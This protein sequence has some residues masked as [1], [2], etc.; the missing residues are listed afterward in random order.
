MSYTSVFGGNT[1]YP[2]DVSYLSIPLSANTPLEWPLESS[3][4]EDPAA[5]II[6]V[7]PSASGFSVVLPNATLTGAGQTILFNNIDATFSFFVKDYAGNTL[8]T[9]TAGTQWQVYLAAT[10]TPAGTWRVFRYGASTATVQPSALAG[11]G[12]TVTGTTLSQSLPVTTFSTTG[13]TVATSNRASAFVW[14]ATGSGTLNLLTAASA[15]NNFFVFVRN[16]GGGDLTVEP[17]GTETINSALSLVLRPGDSAT[18]ITDGVSWYTIGLGQ[19]AVFAF[20]YTSIS[21]TGGTV[22]LSGSQLN[23]IAY[24]FVGTLTSNC[25]IVVP[26]TIQQYWVNNATTGPFQLFIQTSAGTPTGVN[27]GA[28][29]IYY[30]DGT[31]MVLASDPTTLTTPIVISDGGTGS[32][33]ASGARLNLGITSFADAIV[34]ATTGASVRTTISAAASGANSDITSLSGLTTPLSV[35]QGGTGTATA[36][37]TGSVVFAG[38]SGVYSQDN[39]NLFWD[40]TND[41]LGI[42]TST[43]TTK[44]DVVGSATFGAAIITGTGLTTGDAQLELGAN[45][46]GSGLAYID[47]HAISGGDFQARLVRYAGAN[48][49]MDLIQTGTGGMVI[50]NEGSADTVFKTNALERMRI[51]NAGNV[52]IGVSSPPQLLA[53]GNTTDQFGAGVAGAVT[54]AYFGSPSTG[55][56]GI[57]RLAYDRGTGNFDFIGGSVASPATQM[58]ITGTGNV[59]IGTSSPQ[60]LLHVLAGANNSVLVRGPINLGTGGS[61]YAVNSTNSATTPLEFGASVYSFTGGSVGIGTFTPSTTL[62]VVGT[63]TATSF[64]G[65]GT[66]LTGTA[67]AL[68]IGGNAATATSA[69]TAGSVTN[70]ITFNNS[71]SGDASGTTFN[72]SAARTISY[73]TVGAPS[74]GGANATGTWGISISGNAAT[75][76]NATNLNGQAA[77]FYTDIP[78]RLGYTP[79]QQGGGTGQLSNKVYIGWTGS[80]LGVQVD[81]TNFGATWPISINGTA[82]TATTAN[83]LNTG[84]TYTAVGYVSTATAGT[85]LQVGDNSGIRNFGSGST[86]YIDVAGGSASAGSLVLRNTN[87]FTPMATFSGTGTQLTSLGVGTAPSGTAGEIRATNNVTAYY[88]SDARLKENVQPITNALGIVSAVGGKTFDWTDAYIADHGGEDGYFIQKSDFGVIAQDVEAVFPLAVRTREDGTKAVDYEKL[89]AVAF[90]AIA[91]LRAEVNELRQQAVKVI[92]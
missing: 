22:T 5:R 41:R 72:G 59:G 69:T 13:I 78:A 47:L 51:T 44:L 39:A 90:A 27:Q 11:F 8:A 53:V 18:V 87:S 28:K 24:K 73:N 86:I 7:D 17:A 58:T 40:N 3:G 36:L 38:A 70:S 92:K 45:R 54:T 42:G 91:E 2:S 64:T 74:T 65:A 56:G 37:T 43:P 85:A 66:G 10:T 16:E 79:V 61:I 80:Q 26:A 62:Q 19:E 68:S 83:A 63:V 23:R 48:G 15:G 52:G 88:S 71:G 50:S 4:T 33:T 76:S 34:T 55:S 32:T 46:T 81:T 31:N 20:D 67:S 30:C 12:L 35:A 57:R 25:T 1:I 49:G 9:V 60:G 14:T 21:V 75:A 6:D 84:N 82:T 89:V 29:G 77:S